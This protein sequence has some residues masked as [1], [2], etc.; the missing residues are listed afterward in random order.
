MTRAVG[1]AGGVALLCNLDGAIVEVV[2]DDLGVSRGVRTGLHFA[3]LVEGGSAVDAES[4]LDALRA[5]QASFGWELAVP[6]HGGDTSRLHFAGSAVDGGMLLIGAVSRSDIAPFLDGLTRIN[7]EQANALRAAAKSASLL[8]RERGARDTELYDELSRL[9]N[10]LATAQRELAKTNAEL[11]RLNEQKNRFLGMAAH[12]LRNPLDV[13]LTYS[14]FLLD[15]AAPALDG[16]HVEFL[17][18]VESSSEFLLGLVDDLLDVAKIEAGRLDLDLSP[19]DLRAFVEHNAARNR[20]LADR[21]GL[22]LRLSFDANVPPL[23]IDIQKIEQVLNN[24]LGNAIKYS[25]PGGAIDLGVAR[26]GDMI[27]VSVANRGAGISPDELEAIFRPFAT[28][29]ARGTAG[30]RSTGLGLTIAKRIVE[31][32]G[33][34]VRATSTPD[35]ETTFTFTLPAPG[36]GVATDLS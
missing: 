12:D 17:R 30:E 5:Q 29:R 6:V 18:T 19:V 10:E 13:I 34:E 24:L 7:N 33:G 20:T 11:A 25:Q 16:E 15:E 3:D 1:P 22:E 35:G 2:R 21:K 36:Q 23:R 32:H 28:G 31:G 8:T 4:F 27:A 26:E 14:R 9:N